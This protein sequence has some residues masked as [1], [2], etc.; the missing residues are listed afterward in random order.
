MRPRFSGSLPYQL[1]WMPAKKTQPRRTFPA[2]MRHDKTNPS[3]RAPTHVEMQNE[4]TN[5]TMVESM[6]PMKIA[7][8]ADHAGLGLKNQL[9]DILRSDGHQV[10]DAGTHTPESADYPDYAGAVARA[11]ASG[12]ADRGILVCGSGAGMSIAA[13]KI[14]GVRAALGVSREEVTLTRAHNDANVLALGARFLDPD[15]AGDLVRAF[16]ATPFEGGR[17]QRRVDKISSLEREL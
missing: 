14:R 2:Q 10:D 5:A 11:V 8:G 1:D 6:L 3:R 7:I 16:L 12:A 17:H 4:P 9:R 13:N 15:T